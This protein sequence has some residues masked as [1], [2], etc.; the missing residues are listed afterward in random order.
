MSNKLFFMTECKA[1]RLPVPEFHVVEN[2][3]ELKQL[4]RRGVFSTGEKFCLKPLDTLSTT[5]FLLNEDR[6]DVSNV[7]NEGDHLTMCLSS[8]FW[9]FD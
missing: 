8:T 2:T 1:L 4:H 9:V 3:H 6:E 5:P 7:P